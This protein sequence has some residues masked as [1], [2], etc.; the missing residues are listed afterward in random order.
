MGT[1]YKCSAVTKFV[2]L[3]DFHYEI[4]AILRYGLWSMCSDLPFIDSNYRIAAMYDNQ[5]ATV[6]FA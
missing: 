2:W 3:F 5:F 4:V 6:A 1:M